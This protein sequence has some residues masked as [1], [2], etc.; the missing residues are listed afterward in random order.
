[1]ST[2]KERIVNKI[3]PGFVIQE[4][5][6]DKQKFV[7]QNFIA[8]DDVSIEDKDGNLLTE[9]IKNTVREAYLPFEMKQ[10]SENE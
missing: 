4:F 1:M 3:T 6:M 2:G 10:P 5:D 7:R 9:E 8:G